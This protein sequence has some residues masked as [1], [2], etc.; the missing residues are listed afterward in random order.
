V[1]FLV[2]SQRNAPG[3]ESGFYPGL[4]VVPETHRLFL[5]A[6][7]RLLAYDLS[8]PARL[9]ADETRGFWSWS[10]YGEVVI[11]AG[12]LWSRA[13]EPPWTYRVEGRVVVVDMM[14]RVSR[15]DLLTEAVAQAEPGAASAD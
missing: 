5:G 3:A 15:F 14:G 9:W 8:G 6:G 10:R 12:R 7:W 4:V 1:A 11:M 2:V 13:V